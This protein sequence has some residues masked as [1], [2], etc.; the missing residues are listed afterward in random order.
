MYAWF[1]FPTG[2]VVISSSSEYATSFGTELLPLVYLGIGIV[3]AVVLVKY[4][5]RR[6]SKGIGHVGRR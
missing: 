5:R 4:L 3:A 2:A 1:T 6:V